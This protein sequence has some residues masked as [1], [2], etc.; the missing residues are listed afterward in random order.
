MNTQQRAPRV[1]GVGPM[2]SAH[3]WRPSGVYIHASNSAHIFAHAHKSRHTQRMLT[4]TQRTMSDGLGPTCVTGALAVPCPE[5][6]SH[7]RTRTH[8]QTHTRTR[9]HI[10]AHTLTSFFAI[11]AFRNHLHIFVGQ[12]SP[13]CS[14]TVCF[15]SCQLS[16]NIFS[17]PSGCCQNAN[18]SPHRP[19]P[20][21]LPRYKHVHHFS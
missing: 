14:S 13:S 19:P 6:D 2:R 16:V 18:P 12:S 8:S 4:H 1:S 10:R 15:Q 11:Y 3:V 17:Y 7:T 21:S 5:D 9:T 20:S